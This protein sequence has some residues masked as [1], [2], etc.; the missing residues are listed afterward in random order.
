MLLHCDLVYAADTTKLQMPFVNLGVCPEGGSSLLLPL[1][2]GHAR[3]AELLMFGEPFSAADAKSAGL[4]NHVVPADT[5]LATTLARA[6]V[7][8]EKPVTSL[9]LTKDLLKHD[10]RAR[11]HETLLRE[12]THFLEQLGK[13]AATEAFTAFFEKRRPDFRSVGE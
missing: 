4:V 3:A 6:K 2:M 9:R 13:P 12:G 8:A 7:L 1:M 11:L 5:L 10:I